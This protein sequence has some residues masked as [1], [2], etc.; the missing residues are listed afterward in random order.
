MRKFRL[1]LE[2][3]ALFAAMLALSGAAH[4]RGW[5]ERFDLFLLDIEGQVNSPKVDPSIVLLKI[6]DLALADVGAWPWERSVHAELIE[7]LGSYDP[8]AIGYDVLLVEPSRDALDAG[9][10]DAL[11]ES[12]KVVLPHSFADKLDTL[13]E[14]IPLYPLPLFREKAKDIGHVALTPEE[15]GV[16][17]QFVLMYDIEGEKFPHFVV[18]LLEVAG[19]GQWPAS[20]PPKPRLYGTLSEVN[21]AKLQ[22]QRCSM[23]ALFPI[24]SRMRLY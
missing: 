17:R 3:L 21:C 6:D 16:A 1:F 7:R 23:G 8:R 11:S 4:Q 24:T 14:E 9:L 22:L 2:W 18:S 12:G 13:N 5:L 20:V 15:D 10:G 19:E